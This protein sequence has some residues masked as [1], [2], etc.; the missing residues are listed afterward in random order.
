MQDLPELVCKYS[1]ERVLGCHFGVQGSNPKANKILLVLNNS[2]EIVKQQA[3]FENSYE[4][5]LLKTKTGLVLSE[6]L[7]YCKISTEDITITNLFKGILP[8]NVPPNT[9]EYKKCYNN[10]I[11]QIKTMSPKKIIIFGHRGKKLLEDNQDIRKKDVYFMNHPSYIWARTITKK[12]KRQ[13][14]WEKMKN[15]LES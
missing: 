7:E 5:A 1:C 15:F 14:Y 3:L 9:E 4:L 11:E 2:Y 10:L 13:P 12:E 8:K 6:T